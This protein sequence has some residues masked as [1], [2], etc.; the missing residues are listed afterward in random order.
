MQVS[1][2]GTGRKSLPI[3]RIDGRDYFLLGGTYQRLHNEKIISERYAI[4]GGF[5][6]QI[7][8]TGKH[9]WKFTVLTISS[10]GT[11]TYMSSYDPSWMQFSFGDLD[12]LRASADKVYPSDGLEY[13]DVDCLENFT[14]T[15]SHYVYMK[16]D[17]E[18]P[19]NNDVGIWQVPVE[20]WGRDS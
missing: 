14:G 16:V 3:V 2:N 12:S 7:M 9:R 5:D 6:R 19:H 8:N 15:Y 17:W 13:Y 18:S 20:L 11:M 1:I 4:D 10:I